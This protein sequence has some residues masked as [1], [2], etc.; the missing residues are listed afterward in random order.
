M[1]L[2]KRIFVSMPADRWFPEDNGLKWAIVEKIE[3][4][5]YFPEI[6]LD[7]HYR[8]GLCSSEPW[9][10]EKSLALIK[11]CIG[12]FIMGSPRWEFRTSAGVVYMPT[13]F[14]AYEGALA[15]ASHLPMLAIA[16]AD[17]EQRTVFNGAFGNAI[18][19]YQRGDG[20]SW[21][22][23]TLFM[24]PFRHWLDKL[25]RKKDVF[26]GYCSGSAGTVAAVKHYLVET[27]QL[28]VLDWA[29]DFD[30]AGIILSRIE[31]AANLCSLG[32]FLFTKDDELVRD[33]SAG[34]AAPRD[35]VIFE[36]GY[37]IHAK[38]KDNVLIIRESGAKMP[39]DLGGDIYLSLSERDD[40]APLK[41]GIDRFISNYDSRSLL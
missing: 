29:S 36:A 21:L 1:S 12:V 4:A 23:T 27:L 28:S 33:A 34:H 17:I 14:N 41:A 11:R 13:E 6:F 15:H 22:E 5:G 2:T 35:N 20:I 26:L 31:E 30:P 24:T 18:G 39:A 25:N 16:R 32:I 9:S 37:F 3:Q 40:I 7:P 10:P 38:G 8:K 19:V